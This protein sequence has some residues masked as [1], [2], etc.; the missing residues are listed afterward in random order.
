MSITDL[1]VGALSSI[2]GATKTLAT[3]VVAHAAAGGLAS[4]A[5][6]V[7][8]LANYKTGIL[9]CTFS[10]AGAGGTSLQL[11]VQ[12]SYD[13]TNWFD[14]SSFDVQIPADPLAN[15][16]SALLSD[17]AD[18]GALNPA[19]ALPGTIAAKAIRPG[20]W[21]SQLRIWEVVVGTYSPA[22]TYSITGFFEA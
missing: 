2:G 15:Q 21:G 6:V 3:N 13:G 16:L 22:P 19:K 17:Y 11:I 12:G 9:I 10:V 20:P 1:Q 5:P 4:T 14:V 8:G 7:T 18:T